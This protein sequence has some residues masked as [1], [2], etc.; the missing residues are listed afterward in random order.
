MVVAG[1]D[2]NATAQRRAPRAASITKSVIRT[3][4]KIRALIFRNA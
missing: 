4:F 2:D 3:A 1:T